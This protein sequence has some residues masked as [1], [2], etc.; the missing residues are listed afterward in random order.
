MRHRNNMFVF[1]AVMLFC[2]WLPKMIGW[3]IDGLEI[4][5]EKSSR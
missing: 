3:V 5:W 4:L 2:W 1:G